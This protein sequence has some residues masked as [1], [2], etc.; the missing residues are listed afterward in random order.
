[1]GVSSIAAR[2]RRFEWLSRTASRRYAVSRFELA[3]RLL[4]IYRLCGIRP[5]EA[6]ETGLGD[7]S[8]PKEA[9]AGCFDKGRFLELQD[10]LNPRDLI[11]LTEDKA[12]FYSL[13]A[14]LDVPV[15]ELFAVI[16]RGGGWR[17]RGAPLAGRA[18]SFRYLSEEAPDVFVIK[19]ATGVY[20]ANVA[21][22]RRT[23]GGFVDHAGHIQ[24]ATELCDKIFTHPTYERFIVQERLKN[25]L[26]IEQLT[27]C[28]Y[29]QT[30]RIATLIDRQG[31]VRILYA[32]W[33]L[34]GGDLPTDNYSYGRS[35]N[36]TANIDLE[37]GALGPAMTLSPDGVGSQV[38][39][40]HPRTGAA[41]VGHRLPGWDDLLALA[42][43]CAL[44]FRPLRTIGWDIGLTPCGPVV[45]EGNRWWDPATSNVAGP[46][47][48]GV[49]LHPLS[50]A[51]DLLSPQ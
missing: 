49:A 4:R 17:A 40:V 23:E 29:L 42:R 44:L 22:L 36:F 14:G 51:S 39:E 47:A 26:D 37:T 3:L 33:K 38:V 41:L 21:V 20:G 25:H 13:C 18:A 27:G 50:A 10:R 43:R 19:P 48:P 8:L 46:Q 15:P 7:P 16:G 31:L 24:S 35:G 6:L 1:M 11:C 9:L 12:I 2:L 28:A 34:I 32:E 5:V 30:V 45:V